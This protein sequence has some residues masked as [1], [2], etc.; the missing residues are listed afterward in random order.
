MLRD[1]D[2]NIV[3]VGRCQVLALR[4]RYTRLIYFRQRFDAVA[5]F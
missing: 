1:N 5:L 2:M 3:G 4:L